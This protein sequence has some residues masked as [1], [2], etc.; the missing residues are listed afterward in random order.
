MC[1]EEA[2]DA[3]IV[4]TGTFSIQAQPIDGL[5]DFG[6]TYSF[7][8][9]KLVATLRFVPTHR[10][11]PLSVTLLDGKTVKCDELYEDYLTQ[12]YEHEFL[13]DLYKFELND[14][15]VILGMDW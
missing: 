7:I 9:I 6:A 8:S 13:I 3:P 12:I 1:R 4:V 15:G 14:F 10:P 2:E 11:P 5:F